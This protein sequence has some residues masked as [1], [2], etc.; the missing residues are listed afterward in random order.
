MNLLKKAYWVVEKG[1][2]IFGFFSALVA[3]WALIFPGQAISVLEGYQAR[4]TA[5]EEGLKRIEDN[6]EAIID[7]TDAIAVETNRIGGNTDLL[8]A[9]LPQGVRLVESYQVQDCPQASGNPDAVT[10]HFENAASDP[11]VDGVLTALDDSGAVLYQESAVFMN[12]GGDLGVEISGAIRPAR[13][14]LTTEASGT[15]KTV[16]YRFVNWRKTEDSCAENPNYGFIWH[17]GGF[18]QVPPDALTLCR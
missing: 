9:A 6:T 18:V 12:A 13:V 4:F 2:N 17:T 8:V 15:L 7:T 3:I 10:M 5:A 16:E 14:C 1:A 11:V